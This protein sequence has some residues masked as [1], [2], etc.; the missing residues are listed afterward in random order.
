MSAL[1]ER[2]LRVT[3]GHRK[4]HSLTQYIWIQCLRFI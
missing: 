1:L 2:S 3:Q 4:R